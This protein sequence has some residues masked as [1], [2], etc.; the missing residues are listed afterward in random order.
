[1]IVHVFTPETRSFYGLERLWG[2]TPRLDGTRPKEG[3]RAAATRPAPRRKRE[4]AT[5]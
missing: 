2:D 5:R 4:G 3:A 1:V